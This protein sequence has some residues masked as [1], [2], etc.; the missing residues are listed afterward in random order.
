ADGRGAVGRRGGAFVRGTVARAVQQ[1]EHFAGVGQGQDQGVVTPGA[2]VS[3]VH[4]L[5]ALAGGS[6]QRAVHVDDGQRQEVVRLLPPEAL[7]DFVEDV[8]QGVDV[9]RGEAA[10]EVA[11]RGRVGDASGA[12]GI[13]KDGIVAAQLDVLQTG[14]LTE[15][16]VGDIEDMIGLVIGQVDLE[17]VQAPVEGVDQAELAGQGVGGGGA[18]GGQ[19]AAG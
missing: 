3:D 10:A 19:G 16:V 6:Y 13:E 4:A 2:V 14:A 11:G 9:G 15:G 7:A 8:L 18:G 12:Q 5:L 1:P 17:Q